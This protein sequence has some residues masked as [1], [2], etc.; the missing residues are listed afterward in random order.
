M[1]WREQIRT[2]VGLS[3]QAWFQAWARARAAA[4]R[5]ERVAA[6][7]PHLLFALAAGLVFAA[8][9]LFVG[10]APARHYNAGPYMREVALSN[11]GGA[12]HASQEQVQTQP[13]QPSTRQAQQARDREESQTT[14]PTRRRRP[15]SAPATFVALPPLPPLDAAYTPVAARIRQAA[16]RGTAAYRKLEELCDDIGHRLSGS[17]GLEKAVDWAVAALKADGHENVRAEPVM[18]PKW[19]RGAESLEMVEPRPQQLSMLG[20]GGSIGTP[21]EGI[22]AEVLSVDSLERLTELGAQAKGRIVL[23]DVPMPTENEAEGQGYGSAAMFRVN[24]ARYASEHGAVAALVRSAT[25]RSLRSPHTG[26]MR[27]WEASQRIPTACVATEDAAMISRLLAR[28]K[29]VVVTLKMEA[30]DEGMAPS[31]NVVAELRGRERPEEIVVIGGHL[32]SWDVGQGAHDDGGGC[33]MAMEA[34]TLLRSLDLRPRRTIRVVLFTN[35]ENGLR[36]GRAYASDHADEL[37]RH[38]AAIEADSGSHA[39]LG[40]SVEHRDV[41]IQARAVG[42]LREICELIQPGGRLRVR[43]GGSGADIGP[44]QPAGVLLMGQ[45]ADMTHYFDV[46]HTHADTVDKVDPTEL[47]RHVAAMATMAYILADVPE[48]LGDAP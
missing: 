1:N 28:G 48:R 5:R 42:R 7:A 17:P 36:G 11:A 40:F 30:R 25:T 47:D 45:N 32:D 8:L 18:V 12:T 31:A 9:A 26:A 27:Y 19:V 39:L 24:G 46:H 38:V 13:T 16:E 21:P 15:A 20:L 34:L 44:M 29:R 4:T 22:T 3:Q 35:E 23:F 37:G 14:Q 2:S 6:A 10:G 33:V 41:A 43:E